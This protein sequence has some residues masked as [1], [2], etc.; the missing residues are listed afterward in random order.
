MPKEKEKAWGCEISDQDLLTE[1]K[2]TQISCFVIYSCNS[3]PSWHQQLSP[4]IIGLD[5]VA[6][7]LGFI[8]K[9]LCDVETSKADL[10]P[11]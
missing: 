8:F 6:S 10:K 4:G 1:H 9:M 7:F 3:F 2:H 11:Q 5:A